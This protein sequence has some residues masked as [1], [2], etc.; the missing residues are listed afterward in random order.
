MSGIY[1]PGM[2]MPEG[3][4]TCPFEHFG[5]CYGGKAKRIMDIDEELALGVRHRN[6]PLIAVPDHG[7]LIDADA[8]R[9]EIDRARPGRSYEDAWALTVIDNAPTVIAANKNGGENA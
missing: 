7:R 5:D 2:E 8:V 4:D 1:L 9:E 6:C 3:C